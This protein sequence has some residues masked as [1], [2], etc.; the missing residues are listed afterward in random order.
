M[1]ACPSGFHINVGCID[2]T[3]M[4]GRRFGVCDNFCRELCIS[5]VSVAL[6]DVHP[7]I[8]HQNTHT[9]EKKTMDGEDRREERPTVST[10]YPL[11]A[12]PNAKH[13]KILCFVDQIT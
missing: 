5:H 13:Q 3:V 7:T 8:I 2:L 12:M 9:D 6:T 10:A 1:S 11:T 4:I